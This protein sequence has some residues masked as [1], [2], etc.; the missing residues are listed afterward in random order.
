[1]Y[2]YPILN[3]PNF[4]ASH[5]QIGLFEEKQDTGV[6]PE[7]STP[8]REPMPKPP[9]LAA[10]L[11]TVFSGAAS[12]AS[13]GDTSPIYAGGGA[14]RM[15][16]NADCGGPRQCK[17]QDNGSGKLFAGF[18][19]APFSVWQGSELTS[20]LELV[21]YRGGKA[22]LGQR[23]AAS[24]GGAGLSYRISSRETD[25]VSVHARVGMTRLSGKFDGAS[26]ASTG[27]TGGVGMAYAL[28][29]HLS[30]TADYDLLRASFGALARTH[31]HLLTLGAAYKF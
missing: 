5:K 10:L 9:L 21:G 3:V 23:G 4:N 27:V 6:I 24:F 29:K 26:S 1:M 22:S 30:L 16:F 11:L 8:E 2:S 31:V 12:G 15:Q 14:G 13:Y 19:F 18:N 17:G 28:D 7:T 25:A 20:S